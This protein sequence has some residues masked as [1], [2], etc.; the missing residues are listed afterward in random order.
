[1][2]RETDKLHWAFERRDQWLTGSLRTKGLF[3]RFQSSNHMKPY[4]VCRKTTS[5]CQLTRISWDSRSMSTG[6]FSRILNH[7]GSWVGRLSWIWV[8]T[9]H[10][11]SEIDLFSRSSR[12]FWKVGLRSKH[13]D[14]SPDWSV[15]LSPARYLSM[16]RRFQWSNTILRPVGDSHYGS[17]STSTFYVY[18]AQEPV[19]S[20]SANWSDSISFCYQFWITHIL[21]VSLRPQWF[22]PSQVLIKR[23]TSFPCSRFK[24]IQSGHC[25]R[26]SKTGRIS[27]RPMLRSSIASRH[28]AWILL[29][30]FWRVDRH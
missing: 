7:L 30:S 23:Y 14:F 5:A 9:L 26:N 12:N 28:T 3:G 15:Y 20:Y 1:M 8:P 22:L 21:P 6:S 24:V 16:L 13:R 10:L 4:V 2:W 17:R 25:P 19:L 11:L 27:I 29:Q 18:F